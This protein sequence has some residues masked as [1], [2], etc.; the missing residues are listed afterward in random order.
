MQADVLP[1]VAS[2]AASDRSPQLRLLEVGNLK[3][4]F[5][6]KSS[7]PWR[8]SSSIRAVDGVSFNVERGETLGLVGESGCGKTTVARMLVGLEEPT[9]GYMMLNRREMTWDARE[10]FRKQVQ[11]VFQD[12]YASLDPRMSIRDIIME[13][14]TV[15]HV[16]TRKERIDRIDHLMAE[17]GLDPSFAGRLPRQ[18]SGGQRQRV[19]VARALAL[20]PSLIVADEPTSALDVS[21]RAQVINLLREIQARLHLGFVFISHDLAAVR[22][23]SDH[24][25]VMYLGKIVE[26]APTEE[27]LSHPLHPYTKAL[28]SAV[29]VPDPRVEGARR[30]QILK[31]ELP[32]PANP[33][34]GCRFRTRCPL[35]TDRCAEEPEMKA[36]DGGHMAACHFV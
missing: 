9:S 15:Q 2:D 11:M 28:L 4:H 8:P 32:S 18:L 14:M 36:Y 25:A 30:V 34:V 33:P 10:R 20:S 24:I 12:P 7:L 13:P 5:V 3:K 26:Q 17:V 6:K 16:G 1:A 23:V 22:Y 29:P 21:V 19:G 35:A 31:G 27:I